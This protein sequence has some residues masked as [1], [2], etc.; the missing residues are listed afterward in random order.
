MA[1]QFVR[2]PVFTPKAQSLK[3]LEIYIGIDFGTTFSKVSLQIGDAEGTRKYSIRFNDQGDEGDY[4]LPSVLGY[5]ENDKLLVYTDDPEDCGLTPVRYFK[6]SMIEKG[7]PREVDDLR[8]GQTQNDPQ[9]LCSAFYLAHLLRAA[10]RH[11]LE[12]PAV[13]GRWS[14]IRWYVNMGVPVSDF[15]AKPKPIYDEALNVAWNLSQDESLKA[16]MAIPQLDEYYSRWIDHSTWSAR[17]NTVPE[18]YAE[19]I[20]F[21]QART[22]GTGFYSVIDIGGGTVDMAVFL[23]RIDE[24]NEHRIDIY[25]VSQDVCP[26]GYEL[27]KNVL[28]EDI[29]EKM[30]YRSYANCLDPAYHQHRNVMQRTFDNEQSLVHFYMGGARKVEFYH[31]CVDKVDYNYVRGMSAYRGAEECDMLEFMGRSVN[32]EIRGN[33]RLLI[34]QMLAQPFEKMPELSG[35]PWHFKASP[36]RTAPSLEDLQDHLNGPL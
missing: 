16:E 31:G 26:L 1:F 18:L 24:G 30:M 23:K 29:A 34:S 19:I 13:K 10:R 17:L 36:L 28:D 25:C 35:Q 15:N 20:M 33:H 5:D 27:Y 14:Q 21:L 9:R 7:V 12:H 11:I 2:K 4:C 32:L 8:G 22:T 6:Y 3:E